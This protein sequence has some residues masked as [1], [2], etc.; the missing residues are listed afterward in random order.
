[1]TSI[2]E[3]TYLDFC[4]DTGHY[5]KAAENGEQV[6]IVLEN[7]NAYVLSPI[8]YNRAIASA[9]FCKKLDKALQEKHEGKGINYRSDEIQNLLKV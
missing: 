6:I 5:I 1:M 4:N 3:T 9:E 2:I 8:R 7:N